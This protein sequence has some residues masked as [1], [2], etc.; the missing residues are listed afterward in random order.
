MKKNNTK[1][2]REE[3]Q[4]KRQLILSNAKNQIDNIITNTKKQIL[5]ISKKI[6]DG[7]QLAK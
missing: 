7:V 6:E 1:L 3:F 2:T 5:E 4:N